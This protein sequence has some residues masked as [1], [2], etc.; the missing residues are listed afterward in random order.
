MRNAHRTVTRTTLRGP[1]R[2]PTRSTLRGRRRGPDDLSQALTAFGRAIRAHRRLARL[3]PRF[4]DSAVRDREAENRAERRRWMATWE[5]YIA[6]AYGVEPRLPVADDEL[7]PLPSAQIQSEVDLKLAEREMCMVAGRAAMDRWQQRQPHAVMSWNRMVRLLKIGFD[8]GNL[9][10]G[11]D[12]PNPLPEKIAYDYELTDLKRG[13]G[14]E[15]ETPP[16]ADVAGVSPFQNSESGGASVPASRS[17]SDG[18]PPSIPASGPGGSPQ[19]PP[20]SPPRC[21]AWSRWART[22][23]RMRC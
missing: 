7:P 5:P 17:E 6:K 22:M 14:H 12:T 10:C 11:L 19:E 1:F 8:F 20:A 4:F 16:V 23:R 21:D 3:A 18:N 9:A 2:C 13:Y 15:P